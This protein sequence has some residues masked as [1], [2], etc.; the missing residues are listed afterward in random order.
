MYA[1]VISIFA[2]CWNEV[3]NIP[4]FYRR[5]MAEL[6]KHPEFVASFEPGGAADG[7][8]GATIVNLK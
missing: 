3:E 4:V 8:F 5:C 1:K 7:G 2:N 6:K